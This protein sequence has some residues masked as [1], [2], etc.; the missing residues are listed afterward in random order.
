MNLEQILARRAEINKRIAEIQKLVSPERIERGE[1]TSEQVDA[2]YQEHQNLLSE[3]ASLQAE[4]L[5]IRSSAENIPNPVA[6]R[7]TDNAEARDLDIA[8]MTYR[9]KVGLVLARQ[10]RKKPFSQ[11]EKRALGTA[12]TTTDAV[13]VAATAMADG[14]NNAGV[15][16]STSILLDLLREE[17]KLT[18]ILED[19]AF[20]HIKG[21]VNFPYRKGRDKARFKHEGADG[22]DNQSEWGTLAGKTG[23]LQTIFV[24]TDEALAMSDIDF[25]RYLMDQIMQDL[26]EDWAEDLIYSDG[27][28]D[29]FKGLL[30]DQTNKYPNG[31][32][33]SALDACIEVIKAI[34][35]KYRR[36]AKLYVAQDVY[37]EIFFAVDNLGNFKFPVLNNASGISSIGQLRVEVDESIRD[38]GIIDGNVTKYFK[39]NILVPTRIE[40]DRRA[41]GG[42]TEYVASTFCATCPVPGAFVYA[43][44]KE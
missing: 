14:V 34:P 43:N 24:V 31:Y 23:Y 27:T 35:K 10:W 4:E 39:C 2:L 28:G 17:K 5:R 13:Y 37:D 12:L 44:R 6:S 36:G 22:K 11:Q 25:G 15:F 1:T 19:I 30:L 41:R 40:T 8:T 26:G 29:E 9:Q 21:Q 16:I 32:D 18:P 20:T 3:R 7:S 33:G 38:G 42:R